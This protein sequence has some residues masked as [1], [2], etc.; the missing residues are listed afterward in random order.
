M[1]ASAR[2]RRRASTRPSGTSALPGGFRDPLLEAAAVDVV[3]AF[4]LA[5]ACAVQ[6]H[7]GHGGDGLMH[8]CRHLPLALA[9]LPGVD[10]DPAAVEEGEREDA[11]HH[12]QRYAREH[13]V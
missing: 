4:L 10:P 6:L 9:L 7:H 13:R 11:G 8:S 3:E 1:R 5:L 12:E 2:G